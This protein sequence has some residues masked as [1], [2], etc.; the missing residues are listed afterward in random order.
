VPKKLSIGDAELRGI[1]ADP[2]V[3]FGQGHQPE[4]LGLDLAP[5]I[6]A[7]HRILAIRLRPMLV[8]DPIH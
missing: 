5:H 2:L 6:R 4:D 1:T 8:D 7:R 3:I